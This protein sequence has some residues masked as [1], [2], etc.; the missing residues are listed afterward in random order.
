MGAV[1]DFWNA[2]QIALIT[3]QDPDS[4]WTSMVTS[5]ESAIG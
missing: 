4:T 1:W 3:G 2:A 5:V